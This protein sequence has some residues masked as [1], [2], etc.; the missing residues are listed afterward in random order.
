MPINA[1]F[2]AFFEKPLNFLLTIAH[3]VWH[4]YVLNIS[5]SKLAPVFHDFSIN[6]GNILEKESQALNAESCIFSAVTFLY[7]LHF[8]STHA[9]L[10]LSKHSRILPAIFLAVRHLIFG[11]SLSRQ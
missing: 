10:T 5:Y 6:N 3:H 4:L 11:A 7:I 2:M 8:P 1:V 9:I